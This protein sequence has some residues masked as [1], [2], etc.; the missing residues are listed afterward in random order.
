[1]V[2]DVEQDDDQNMLDIVTPSQSGNQ[3]NILNYK[4]KKLPSLA[5]SWKWLKGLLYDFISLK[6]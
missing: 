6:K 3:Y 2:A 4:K 1:M 5:E